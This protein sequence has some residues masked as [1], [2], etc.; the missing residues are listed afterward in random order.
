MTV[1]LEDAL[2]I[3]GADLYHSGAMFYLGASS[4]HS[5]PWDYFVRGADLY[6][7][8]PM[9]YLGSLCTALNDNTIL[10]VDSNPKNS[11]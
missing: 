5:G 3:Q 6:H 4:Q 1:F 2:Y 7:T 11:V 8:G 10:R 9:L